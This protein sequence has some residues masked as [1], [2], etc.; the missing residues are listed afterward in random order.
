MALKPLSKNEDL[1]AIPLD[2][3]VLVELEPGDGVAETVVDGPE[4]KPDPPARKKEPTAD[5]GAAALQTQMEDMRKARVRAE[6]ERDEARREADEARRTVADTEA[7]LIQ[8]G[9]TAAQAEEK[10]ARAALKL[11][12]ETGDVD[13]QADAMARIGRAAGDIREYERAAAVQS[14]EKERAKTEP[15]TEQRRLSV[16]ESIDARTDLTDTERKWLKEHQDAWVDPARNNELGV[17]Y[18]RAVKAGH[19]RGTPAYFTFIE[20][21]MGYA[22]PTDDHNRGEGADERTVTVQAPVSRDT[23][24]VVTGRP[25]S[26]RVELTPEERQFARTAGISDV[27]YA[28]GKIQ[29]AA[30]KAADP[31]KYG[32]TR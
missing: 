1:A 13:A 8:N 20:D 27:A 26:A 19:V 3:P 29:L 23:R 16:E 7:D 24:S 18:G 25:Q 28:R 2:E 15:R 11:A 14:E 6:R 10:A 17:A 32:R 9:L 30:A 31:E 22:K 21:F 12:T 4:R 5:D